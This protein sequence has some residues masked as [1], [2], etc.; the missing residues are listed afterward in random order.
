[1]NYYLLLG[2]QGRSSLSWKVRNTEFTFPTSRHLS[3]TK[4]D[5]ILFDLRAKTITVIELSCPA[6]PNMGEKEIEKK[7][8]YL[9][10]S[11]ES[12]IRDT[13]EDRSVVKT[14]GGKVQSV[15]RTN[16]VGVVVVRVLARCGVQKCWSHET[17]EDEPNTASADSQPPS[18][19]AGSQPFAYGSVWQSR[20]TLTHVGAK[21][22]SAATCKHRA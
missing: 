15:G 16:P 21:S 18:S 4:P 22:P 19:L 8:K 5:I 11:F 14:S 12:C 17:E 13:R 2:R 9:N 3:S 20:P 10:L 7:G 1:M 6:E